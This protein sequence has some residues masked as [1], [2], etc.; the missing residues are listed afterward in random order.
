MEKQNQFPFILIMLLYLI[1]VILSVLIIFLGKNIYDNI[2]EERNTNYNLRVSLSYIANKLRQSDKSGSVEI[3]QV[4]GENALVLNEEYDDEQ[5][6]TW[7]YFYEGGIYEMFT[8]SEN[9]FDLSDGM[10]LVDA[11]VFNIEKVRDDLYRFYAAS[12]EKSS[13]LYLSIYSKVVTP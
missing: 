11:D 7:I 1:I 5:Y 3:K 13:E 12:N 2:N 6:Q 8:D 10:K 9:T 4:N